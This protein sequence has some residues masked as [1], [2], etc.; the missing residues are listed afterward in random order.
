M[1]IRLPEAADRDQ[2]IQALARRSDWEAVE[3]Q[4]HAYLEYLEQAGRPE[5]DAGR[6]RLLERAAQLL[7]NGIPLDP[8][9]QTIVDSV[10]T[11]A[12]SEEKL[13]LEALLRLQE[14][15]RTTEEAYLGRVRA[16]AE[17]L[18]DWA[19]EPRESRAALETRLTEALRPLLDGQPKEALERADAALRAEVP[20]ARARHDRA[21]EVG[22]GIVPVAKELGSPTEALEAALAADATASP[23]DWPDTVARLERANAEAGDA[24]RERVTATLAALHTT[25]DSLRDFGV[26]P[27]EALTDLE[28][29]SA[30]VPGAAT[31]DIP[32]LLAAARGATEDPVVAVVASLLDG[33]RPRLVEA[34]RL[35]RDASEVFAAMNRAREALRLRI[36]SEAL[37]ASQEAMDR[38]G[39]LTGDLDSAREEA[40]SLARLLERLGAARFPTGP[41]LDRLARARDRLDR[42][43]LQG[44]SA[45]LKEA[46]QILG[47]EAARHFSRK[48]EEVGRVLP[49][50]SERGFLPADGDRE[51]DRVRALLDEGVIADAGEQLAA[52]EVR[53]RAAAGPF[54]ARRVEELEKGFADIPDEALVQP[55]RRL[56][57]DA[58]VNL[59]IK[60]DLTASLESLKRAERE[61]SA[62]FAAHASSLVE[63]LEDERRTLEAMGGTGDE[64]QRQI[65]E[66]QQ[67]FNMGD[68]VKASR[69]SQE[70][71]ARVHQQ[72]LVRTEDEISHAKLALVELAKMGVEAGAL[73]TGLEQ[74]QG[75]AAAQHYSDAYRSAYETQSAAARLKTQAQSILD[76]LA[77]ANDLW[78]NLKGEGGAADAYREKIRL[79]KVAYQALDFEGAK[80][81]LEVLLA[82]LKSEQAN[83]E[84]RRL[85]GE[86]DLLR[87]DAQ[88]LSVPTEEIAGKIAVARTALEEGRSAE[89]LGKARTTHGEVNALV[90][91]VLSENLRALE[92]DYE[93][94]QAAGL[95]VATVLELLGE[96]RRRLALPV[97]TGV[98]E[99]LESARSRLIETRGFLEHA[100][101]AV[102]R[103]REAVSE[104]ELVR[105]PGIEALR[106]RRGE[107]EAALKKR[108]YARTVELAGTLERETLQV[109]YQQ[110]SKTLAAF[111]GVVA[112][113]RQEGGVTALAENLLMQSR[114]ALEEGRALEALQLVASS[115]SELE[116][117]QLQVRIAQGSLAAME[118][119]IAEAHHDGIHA[120]V[121]EEEFAKARGAFV[122]H[123]YADVLELSIDAS[124]ALALSQDNHRRS[125]EA[126]ETA[127]RQVK[128]A[129]EVGAD[130]AAVVGRLESARAAHQAGEYAEAT[131][132]A[133]EAAEAARWGVD[134]LYTGVLA[135]TRSLL[136]TAREA[137]ATQ[138]LSEA[139]ESVATAEAALRARDWRRATALLTEARGRCVVALDAR[140]RSRT[141]ELESLYVLTAEPSP[142][143]VAFR[144]QALTR[145]KDEAARGAYAGAFAT[146]RDEESRAR[147]GLRAELQ[148]R[149]AALKDK[150]WIGEK[151]GLDTTPV[152][153]LFSEAQLAVEAGK[154]EPVRS[155]VDRGQE[156]LVHLIG[157]RLEEKLR[158][159][160]TELVFA[161]DGLHVALDDVA[162]R[163]AKVGPLAKEGRV[164]DAAEIVLAGGEE[165]NR[166]KA[167]HRELL[168]LHYL[169]DAALGRAA[170]RHL[171]T[172]EARKL[173]DESLRARATDYAVALDRARAAL[174]LL[175]G[176]LK[177]A[178]PP[179]PFW[180]FKRTP[181]G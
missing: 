24:L 57:A 168:N 101:R 114:T 103:A 139:E 153:E 19:G 20:L 172:T 133:R 78:Q 42:L 59:R 178:E 126:L 144:D 71:R 152:M 70:I 167:L 159:V 5:A 93:V 43:D 158:E 60:E 166:R 147:E 64:I 127:D 7:A 125:R 50:A 77:E 66:V 181:S 44:A 102:K 49:I 11:E 111:Q 90:R 39:Q 113:T 30:Q 128:E 52:L 149:V 47:E 120:K 54:I 155:L 177:G 76:G 170:E 34:R 63:M 83:A 129:L 21:T 45:A 154:V 38:V 104:A 55:V 53:L 118:K 98:A 2:A 100:E 163:L 130:V 73:R 169:I 80:E 179:A 150:L 137:G 67:I 164:L 160:Q 106:E 97:P 110:V 27:T 112:R 35:G 82:L 171:D 140:V 68:F 8:A 81:T 65:D 88:R 123:H 14:A 151:L 40:D 145:V 36:Y 9:T 62:I 25:L 157:G 117:A 17:A 87:E 75:A 74:A 174:K 122:E 86:C 41:H 119:K 84:T 173:L 6:A 143:E 56:L 180:P 107:V 116:L 135:E 115:E 138:G 148:S 46:V 156:T 121:A 58:D 99:L 141:V 136:E 18:A 51:F 95:D 31:P 32:R 28:E 29:V 3:T 165:L 16:R 12:F 10:R 23:L 92:R 162:G 13:R 132:H 33:V 124:D 161:Q 134:R 175:Q 105:A 94:A 91:P 37:A 26:D 61:F 89:A 72:Q 131:R 4:S 176:Q 22:R 146:L 79:T 142:T 15:L 108:A 69:A 109:V 48:L 1:K 96:S 85:L